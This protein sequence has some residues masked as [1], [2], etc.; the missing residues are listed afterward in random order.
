MDKGLKYLL[1]MLLLILG[2][3]DSSSNGDSDFCII[4]CGET[5]EPEDVYGCIDS[6]AVNYSSNATVSDSTCEYS[7]Y[8]GY[9]DFETI[10]GMD[11]YANPTEN[12]GDGI[13][14]LCLGQI[15][16]DSNEWHIPPIQSELSSPYPNPFYPTISISFGNASESYTTIYIL[17]TDYTIIDTLISRQLDAGYHSIIWDSSIFPSGYYR[18]VADFGDVEC[19]H[20]VYKPLDCAGIVGGDAVEDECGECGGNGADEGE[21]ALWGECY[22]IEATTDLVLIGSLW[23]YNYRTIPPEIGS[24]TNLTTLNLSHNQLTALPEEICDIYSNLSE[25]NVSDNHICGELPSCLTAEDIGEQ[26]CP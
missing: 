17:N 14:G 10:C 18:I 6:N 8:G 26:D 1:L 25:F 23:Y 7:V 12:I 11:E 13:C 21:V 9:P 16:Y 20:N 3:E 24:L 22:S 19:F 2:C 5:L 4:F 15:E